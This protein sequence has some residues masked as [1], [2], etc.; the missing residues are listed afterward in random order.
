MELVRAVEDE[1]R[2]PVSAKVLRE[3]LVGR[4][5]ERVPFEA[6]VFPLTDPVTNVAAAPL[7]HAPMLPWP[8]LPEMIRWRYLTT[9]TRPNTMQGSPAGSLR[10][11][12]T[13]PEDSLM[14][15]HVQRELGIVDTAVV[16]FG[17]RYGSW[18]YLELWRTAAEFT[19]E[20]LALLTSMQTFVTAGLR[21]AVAR[22]FVDP[23]DQLLPVGPAVVVLAPDLSVR[24]RT[25]AAAQALLQ[26]LP[27]DEPMAPIPAA[28]YNVGAALIA[29][30]EGVPVGEPWSRVHLGGSRWVTVKASR[31]GE[32]I[33]VS[34]EPSSASERMDL[35]ARSHGLSE[36][37]AEVLG[38]LGGGLDTREIAG[39][40]FLSEHTVND[41]VKAMLAKTGARTRQ[42]MLARVAGA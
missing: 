25:E 7:A 10:T 35:F 6:Y 26:L 1:C 32:D 5:R 30:E 38:L 2:R 41:H 23:A 13:S 20:E 4:L 24:T 15:R 19:A 9:V 11:S 29:Q 8:R 16:A 3:R 12:T 28:A 17:D 40:L 37:E 14:W 42:V 34:I 21:A 36:R 33:A 27:P 39:A 22:T 31:L 18:G